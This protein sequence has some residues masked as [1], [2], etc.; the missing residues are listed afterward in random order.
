MMQLVIARRGKVIF[1][2]SAGM[3]DRERGV[4]LT[5][6]TIMRMFSN[7]KMV[8]SV[9]AMILVERAQLHLDWPVEA[10]LPCFRD[11]AVFDR[12]EGD[13]VVTRPPA[14][15]MTIQHL[16]THCSGL[17]YGFM[18]GPVAKLYA[19]AGIAFDA[20]I[21]MGLGLEGLP[22]V[23]DTPG[24]L[25][26]MVERLAALP[27]VCDPGTA[28]HYGHSTDVLGC[29][30]EAVSGRLLPDFLRDEVFAPLGMCDTGFSVAAGA[31]PRLAALYRL[32]PPDGFVLCDDPCNSPC[33]AP[34]RHLCAGGS[35]LLST[36]HD[37]TRFLLMLANGGALD[38]ARLLSRKSVAFMMT[39]HLPP[40]VAV[41]ADLLHCREGMGFGLGGAPPLP[42]HAF[43]PAPPPPPTPRPAR[44]PPSAPHPP[45]W[46]PPHSSSP[47]PRLA[48]Q[49]R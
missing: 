2:A 25:R 11:V 48:R 1:T 30:V 6:K 36:L 13:R 20:P 12:M 7:T 26:R 3:A 44:C 16:L 42:S 39:N 21:D 17:T 10:Y 35:G 8:V 41:P 38:G 49:A 32:A 43:P 33:L 47:R 5:D 27:L 19:R 45:V 46:T 14:R 40:G 4:P 15:K 31:A 23:P 34:R 29:V 22:A 28:F 18:R 24:A 37:F 9:A